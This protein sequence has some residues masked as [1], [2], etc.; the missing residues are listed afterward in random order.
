LL[1]SFAK[2]ADVKVLSVADLLAGCWGQCLQGGCGRSQL[3][4]PQQANLCQQQGAERRG[5][6]KKQMLMQMLGL[7]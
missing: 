2:Y 6:P 1:R 7:Q 4:E 3:A 5:L